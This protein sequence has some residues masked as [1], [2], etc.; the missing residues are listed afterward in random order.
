MVE[1]R[2]NDLD[3]APTPGL[4]TRSAPNIIAVGVVTAAAGVAVLVWPH[5]TLRV[6]AV[7]FGIYA[8][9][10]GTVRLVT[11]IAGN[12]QNDRSRFLPTL[13]GIIEILVGILVLRH[14]FQTLTV[15]ILLF[16]LVC[17][18]GGIVQLVHAVNTPDMSGRPWAI[19]AACVTLLAGIVLLVYPSVSLGVLTWLIGFQLLLSGAMLIGWG[20]A[21]RGALRMATSPEA[22][23]RSGQHA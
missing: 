15:L 5:A 6:I 4:L 9:V 17:V 14:P 20:V 23:Q 7:V 11:A 22:T 1:Q 2:T 12:R 19:G 21:L 16:G 13:L 3:R 8:L 18:L 10:T